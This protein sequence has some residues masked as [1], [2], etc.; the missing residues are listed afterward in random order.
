M[1][2]MKKDT[3]STA[4]ARQRRIWGIDAVFIAIFLAAA[5]LVAASHVAVLADTDPATG[6]DSSPARLA[7]TKMIKGVTA[8]LGD[9]A[10]D[11]VL[12]KQSRLQRRLSRRGTAG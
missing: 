8:D 2:V 6:D 12:V 3:A 9:H 11:L 7:Q 5:S 1:I 10:L 4:N